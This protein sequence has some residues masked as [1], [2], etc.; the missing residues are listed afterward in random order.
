MEP[1]SSYEAVKE[2]ISNSAL[3][4]AHMHLC[5]INS[6]SLKDIESIIPLVDDAL[7]QDINITVGAYYIFS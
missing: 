5:H 3:T 6:T 1:K 2:L 7:A 4:G